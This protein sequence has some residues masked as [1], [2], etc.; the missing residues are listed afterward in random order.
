MSKAKTLTSLSAAAVIAAL[1]TGGCGE[2][3]TYPPAPGTAG[4]AAHYEAPGA[5]DERTAEME[6]AY[7][8]L[9]AEHT[10][11][12]RGVANLFDLPVAYDVAYLSWPVTNAELKARAMRRIW[13]EA[14]YEAERAKAIAQHRESYVFRLSLYTENLKENRLGGAEASPWKAFLVIGGERI[15]PSRVR[16]ISG[17]DSELAWLFPP[18]DRFEKLYEVEFPRTPVPAE[19]PARLELTGFPDTTYSEWYLSRDPGAPAETPPPVETKP[20]K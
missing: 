20:V 11:H 1:G 17:K 2:K 14:T 5:S 9:L 19:T 13:D 10:Q 12:V 16:Q 15:A 6:E 8:A 18:L 7:H 4:V 3:Q